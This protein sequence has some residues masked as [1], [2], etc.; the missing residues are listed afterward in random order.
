MDQE[1]LWKIFCVAMFGEQCNNIVS[2]HSV[3]KVYERCEK[4]DKDMLM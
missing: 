3:M 1:C 4:I 2:L